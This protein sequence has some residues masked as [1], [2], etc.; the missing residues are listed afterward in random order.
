MVDT[1]PVKV[2]NNVHLKHSNRLVTAQLNI[3]SYRNKSASLSTMIKYYVELLLI[4]EIKTDS[5][6][7]TAQ[8][9][10]DGY[11]IPRRDK[12]ENGGGLL[13]YVR[14]DVLSTLWKTD[15]KIEAFFCRVKYK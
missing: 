14:E 9:H 15:S 1:D 4:S 8:F 7:P 3:N 5:S 12:D 10:I 11:T 13:F 6:F 2:Q